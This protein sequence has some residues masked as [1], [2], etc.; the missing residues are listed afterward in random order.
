MN[1]INNNVELTYH[2]QIT[3]QTTG[4]TQSDLTIQST[5]H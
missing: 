1:G 5:S 2:G 4:T 3:K